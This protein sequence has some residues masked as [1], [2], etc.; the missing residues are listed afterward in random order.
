[1]EIQTIYVIAFGMLYFWIYRYLIGKFENWRF[2][3]FNIL[4]I[5]GIQLIFKTVF[6]LFLSNSDFFVTN[7]F[8]TLLKDIET[9]KSVVPDADVQFLF[10]TLHVNIPFLKRVIWL[11]LART[12][13]STSWI[14][15]ISITLFLDTLLHFLIYRTSTITTSMKTSRDLFKKNYLLFL[16]SPAS[17][18][19]LLQTNVDLYITFIIVFSAM[20]L[21]FSKR[22]NA[23]FLLLGVLLTFSI[24]LAVLSIAFVIPVLIAKVGHERSRYLLLLFLPFCCISLLTFFMNRMIIPFLLGYFVLPSTGVGIGVNLW[25]LMIIDTNFGNFFIITIPLLFLILHVVRERNAGPMA[26]LLTILILI[27]IW[28][29]LFNGAWVSLILAV[30]VVHH[31]EEKW[32][33]RHLLSVYFF[34]S[35]IEV[36]L[37]FIVKIEP[38]LFIPDD[39]PATINFFTIFRMVYLIT[40][41]SYNMAIL[42]WK[43]GK[44]ITNHVRAPLVVS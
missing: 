39:Y 16:L 26:I 32:F 12:G 9:M 24:Y 2:Y 18:L 31:Q 20:Y 34:F 14:P 27:M 43:G 17:Y 25:T 42:F 30:M 1:M 19:L 35:L 28:Q 10:G 15:I 11:V 4:R 44:M 36:M 29:P 38:G 5:L 3:R 22:Y 6:M 8:F 41:Q 33:S 7:D 23:A 40:F 21:F 37:F 13:F